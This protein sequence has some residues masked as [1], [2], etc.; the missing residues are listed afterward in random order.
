MLDEALYE[1][2]ITPRLKGGSIISRISVCMDYAI[3]P[4]GDD[5]RKPWNIEVFKNWR[6]RQSTLG[7]K[8]AQL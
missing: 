7:D 5:G 6:R 1:L 2:L 3:K 4:S 8:K